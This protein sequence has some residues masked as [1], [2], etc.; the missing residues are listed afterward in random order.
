[1][2]ENSTGSTQSH[3][4]SNILS[5]VNRSEPIFN[6]ASEIN[7]EEHIIDEHNN[8]NN[9]IINAKQVKVG[10]DFKH[11]FIDTNLVRKLVAQFWPESICIL[12]IIIYLIYYFSQLSRVSVV[13]NYYIM[14]YM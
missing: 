3:S 7:S 1:M 6:E 14:H 5:L 13:D 4:I 11:H 12:V 10:S 8:N 2:E 9:I